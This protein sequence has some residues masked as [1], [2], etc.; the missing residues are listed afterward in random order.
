MPQ[1]SR[2]RVPPV[3]FPGGVSNELQDGFAIS[4]RLP[5]TEPFRL[6]L[7]DDGC[8]ALG[9][10]LLRDKARLASWQPSASALQTPHRHLPTSDN[11]GD[12]MRPVRVGKGHDKEVASLQASRGDPARSAGWVTETQAARSKCF[13]YF[14][15]K[16]MAHEKGGCRMPGVTR[17]ATG[18]Y[19]RLSQRVA[20]PSS[21][22]VEYGTTD[23]LSGTGGWRGRRRRTPP[24]QPGCRPPSSWEFSARRVGVTR[25]TASGLGR[26][27]SGA[28]GR[29]RVSARTAHALLSCGPRAGGRRG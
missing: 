1:A 12:L 11:F 24:Q 14:P 5:V 10:R 29:A 16:R 28:A 15:T 20:K 18:Y 4:S 8:A 21:P 17:A 2:G 13:G 7:A 9:L 27:L 19:V 22:R 25:R 23:R 6:S 26:G 3:T